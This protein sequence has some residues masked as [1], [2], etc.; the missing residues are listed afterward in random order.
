MTRDCKTFLKD[1]LDTQ[2][3]ADKFL[4]NGPT[5]DGTRP[6]EMGKNGVFKADLH[7]SSATRWPRIVSP[8]GKVLCTHNQLRI[9]FVTNG[10][11][12]V[13]GLRNEQKM[14]CLRQFF[15]VVLQPDDLGS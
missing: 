7:S 3:A 14:A 6:A 13:P 5:R 1:S 15:A 2:P 4:T 12:M 8:S 11:V 10:I 9:K